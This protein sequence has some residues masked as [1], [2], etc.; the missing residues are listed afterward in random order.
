MEGCREKQQRRNVICG[1]FN[2]SLLNLILIKIDPDKG[3]KQVPNI[4]LMHT[5]IIFP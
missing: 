3:I 1:V 5:L 4:W 2:S